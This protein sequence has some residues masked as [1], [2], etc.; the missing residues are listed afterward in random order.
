MAT[1]YEIYDDLLIREQ[2]KLTALL[3]EL[4]RY[5]DPNW[6]HLS[7]DSAGNWIE[8]KPALL[9]ELES[10]IEWAKKNIS[11]YALRLESIRSIE[12]TA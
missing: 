9:A 11:R 3:G 2:R 8:I 7:K 6:H 4:Q 1:E 12:I 5:R 10:S